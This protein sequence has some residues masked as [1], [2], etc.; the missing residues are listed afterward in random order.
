ML[1]ARAVATRGECT[2]RQVGAVILD[3]HHR[4]IGAGYNGAPPGQRSCLDGACPRGHSDVAPESSYD[5][6]P[7]ACIAIHAELNALMDCGRERLADGDCTLYCTEKPCPGCAKILVGFGLRVI[8]P[9]NFKE[10]Q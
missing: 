6:G 1:V 5:S 3:R 4:I 10:V 9:G 7:G 2:R 8:H